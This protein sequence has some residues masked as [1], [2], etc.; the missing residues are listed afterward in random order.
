MAVEYF[1]YA[2]LPGRAHFKCERLVAAV[3]TESCADM[4]RA[5][6]QGEEL[7]RSCCKRCP[8][9]AVH[10]GEVNA[11]TSQLKGAMICGRCH[12]TA[13]RLIHG[14]ECVSCYNRSR[15]ARI[16]RNA[17]GTVPT[18]LAPLEPRK[19]WFFTTGG[20]FRSLAMKQTVDT[21]ELVVAALRDTGDQVHFAWHAAVQLRQ[22]ALW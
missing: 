6:N 19:I 22:A 12:R 20:A 16:G 13:L 8:V 10:A 7:G 1:S 14:H 2:A 21:D 3:S 9:G 11:S 4:W 17:K 15:E 5:A 18:K